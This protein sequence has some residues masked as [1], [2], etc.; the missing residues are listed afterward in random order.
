MSKIP[1]IEK[2]KGDNSID[3]KLWITQ[4][5]VHLKALDIEDEKRLDI[6]FVP[7]KGLLS[8]TYVIYEQLMRTIP[9]N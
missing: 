5:E 3:F 6:L 7:L 9:T 4:F 2:F 1:N 8:H